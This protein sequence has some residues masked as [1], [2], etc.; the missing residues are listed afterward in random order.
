MAPPSS[1]TSEKIIVG[2]LVGAA[3]ALS[4]L[5]IISCI[6]LSRTSS[7]TNINDEDTRNVP[8][9]VVAPELRDGQIFTQLSQSLRPSISPTRS[10]IPSFNPTLQPS[11]ASSNSP[12]FFL[13]N[14]P[15][16]IPSS[17]PSSNPVS[18]P[19]AL[20]SKVPSIRPSTTPTFPPSTNPTIAPSK[21]PSKMLPS[22]PLFHCLP[23]MSQLS[24]FMKKIASGN[25]VLV[26]LFSFCSINLCHNMPFSLSLLFGTCVGLGYFWQEQEDEI[27]W[28]MT[29]A[30]N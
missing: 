16:S 12:S 17:K 5:G 10:S 2:S 15:S 4:T 30:I 22:A 3:A 9:K 21:V 23:Q 13:S 18:S 7:I 27:W 24:R 25:L 26:V 28:C 29:C 14:E 8:S 1:S 11:A 20:P 6:E 19:S